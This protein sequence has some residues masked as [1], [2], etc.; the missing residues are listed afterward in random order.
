M[1]IIYPYFI[2][3]RRVVYYFISTKP[4]FRLFEAKMPLRKQ[5][6]NLKQASMDALLVAVQERRYSD[7][8]Y[9][10]IQSLREFKIQ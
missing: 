4:P 5:P 2:E 1:V 3:Y 10:N 8:N 6:V 7:Y 9:L